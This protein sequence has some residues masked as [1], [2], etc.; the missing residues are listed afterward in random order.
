MGVALCQQHRQV[1]VDDQQAGAGDPGDQCAAELGRVLEPI[2]IEGDHPV[3]PACCCWLACAAMSR[4]V[5]GIAA[6]R[7]GL[8]EKAVL[9]RAPDPAA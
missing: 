9:G 3:T 4:D 8:A 1:P 6:A 5:P 7:G 2:E